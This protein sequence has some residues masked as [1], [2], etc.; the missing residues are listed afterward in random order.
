MDLTHANWRKS[1]YSTQNGS[2][3]EVARPPGAT[4]IAVRDSQDPHGP[5][6]TF[7]ANDWRDFLHHIKHSQPRSA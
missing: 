4:A 5:T 2:C 6:L 1:S 7:T 3:V